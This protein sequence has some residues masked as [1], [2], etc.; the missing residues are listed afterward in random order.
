MGELGYRSLLGGRGPD[1]DLKVLIREV[2]ETY[3]GGIVMHFGGGIYR[4]FFIE[5]PLLML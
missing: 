2:M 5:G 4:I 3:K 1:I